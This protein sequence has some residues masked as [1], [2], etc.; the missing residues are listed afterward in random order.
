MLFPGTTQGA[1][2]RSIPTA[3]FP[4]APATSP[5]GPHSPSLYPVCPQMYQLSTPNPVPTQPQ[6]SPAPS[7]PLTS[8]LHVRS[9]GLWAHLP[10]DFTKTRHHRHEDTGGQL[11]GQGQRC[12]AGG[13][14]CVSRGGPTQG[15]SSVRGAREVHPLRKVLLI[16]VGDQQRIIASL[17]VTGLPNQHRGIWQT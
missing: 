1:P 14:A 8:D 13:S 6:L 11:C 10:C 7:Q 12:G 4:P 5:M 2:E 15:S 17:P 3:A 9:W 16:R